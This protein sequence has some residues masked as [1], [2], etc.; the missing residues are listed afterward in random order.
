VPSKIDLSGKR[1]NRLLVVRETPKRDISGNVYW[2]CICDCG[3]Q[4][5]AA[6]RLLRNGD[7]Q[8]CGCYH[9]EIAGKA[10]Q[11]DL[12]GEQFGLLTVL[13]RD[14]VD[15]VMGSYWQC[16]CECGQLK[17]VRQN[18]LISGL[19]KSCGCLNHSTDKRRKS[20]TGNIYGRLLVMKYVRTVRV[21][22]NKSFDA[23]WLCKCDCGQEREVRGRSLRDGS[24]VSCGCYNRE[25]STT[26]GL[27]QT[28]EY[29]RAE[30]RRRLLSK[31]QRTPTWAN[32][33]KILE[34][35]KSKPPGTHV[36]H[37]IPLHHRLVSG[38]H[39]ENNLQYL[40]GVENL[41]KS[42][43]FDPDDFNV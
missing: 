33:K 40:S 16:Q 37:I 5:T 12:A 25:I 4:H 10:Q 36:D 24:T 21:G 15:L 38:L 6:G 9:R 13:Q 43:K 17:V 42:N 23:V 2:D 28:P 29:R 22:S 41:R 26:H 34:F 11:S 30:A 19:T 7:I 3:R 1:F 32:N 18:S 20:I 14:H 8:S 31:I 35:Y 27:S 39:V